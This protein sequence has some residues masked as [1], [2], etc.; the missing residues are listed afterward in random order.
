MMK[1]RQLLASRPIRNALDLIESQ[2]AEI[3]SVTDIAA[4]VS[5]SVRALDDGFQRYVGTPP[6]TYLRQV[7]LTR[8]QKDLVTAD[9]DETTVTAVARKW[10]FGHYGSFAA[11]YQRR[12]VRK[13]SETLR[14]NE[15]QAC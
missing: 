12:F 1:P 9:P 14:T 8:A 10:G 7:R 4:A 13:P 15:M 5:L 2:P 3:E 6:M 11:D